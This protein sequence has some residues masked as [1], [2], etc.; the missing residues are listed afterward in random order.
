ML[1]AWKEKLLNQLRSLSRRIIIYIPEM[2]IWSHKFAEK[3]T[4]KRSG[5]IN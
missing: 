5:L 3:S 1:L 2:T 4:F